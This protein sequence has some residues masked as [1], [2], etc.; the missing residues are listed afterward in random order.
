VNIYSEEGH[1]T[2]VK[3]YLP[4]AQPSE[5]APAEEA[6]P[7][8]AVE[9]GG[10][11]ILVVEDEAAVREIAVALLEEQGYSVLEA[12]DGP[13]A[14]KILDEHPDIDLLLTDVVMPGGMGGPELAQE[15]RARRPDFK[16]LYTSGY[17][18]NAIVHRGVLNEGVEL[19]GKPYQRDELAQKV[20]RVLDS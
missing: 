5:W 7:G 19:I 12:E 10:E 13:A 2:T 14:L 11:T 4:R 1:G 17:T 8:P 9:A 6:A 3:L 18:E 16:V 15:G 20:R